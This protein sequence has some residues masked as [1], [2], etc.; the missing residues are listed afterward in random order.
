ML[1]ESYNIEWYIQSILFHWS[2][3]KCAVEG[4]FVSLCVCKPILYIKQYVNNADNVVKMKA[5]TYNNNVP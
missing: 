5:T 3:L 2:K 4:G 1:V